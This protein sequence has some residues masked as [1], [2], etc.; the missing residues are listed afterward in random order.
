MKFVLVPIIEQM[1]GLYR[2]PISEARFHEYLAMLQGTKKGDLVL[3]IGGFNPMAKAHVSQKLA[4]LKALGAEEI[5]EDVAKELN[6]AYA[7]PESK[8]ISLVLN[9]ADDLKG[10]WT[11]YYTTDFDSKFKINAL[12]NRNFCTPY[13]WTS[14]EYHAELIR[15]RTLEYAYRTIYWQN[16]ARLKTLEDHV[17][18]EIFVSEKTNIGGHQKKEGDKVLEQFYQDHKKEED[19]SVIFNFF[20]GDK[21][22]DL[23][24]FPAYGIKGST[25]FDFA[26]LMAAKRVGNAK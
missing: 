16:H 13:F 22:S 23:L 21:V 24:A 17:A 14:E 2:K 4:A 25:G 15:Q 9:L 8:T 11:N 20:Y 12:V 7:K 6:A 10:G 26:R 1:E 18:Q 3:P 19:Y 5:I